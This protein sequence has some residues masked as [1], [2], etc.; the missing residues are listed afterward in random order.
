GAVR[1]D[2]GV[3]PD[4]RMVAS[5]LPAGLLGASMQSVADKPSTRRPLVP[6]TQSP[7]EIRV[8][9]DRRA[10]MDRAFTVLGWVLV[11]VSLGA[12]A[13]LLGDLFLQ[14]ISR[15]DA[16]FL[17]NFPSR[18]PESAGILS[19]WVGSALLMVVTASV[20]VPMGVAAGLYL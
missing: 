13:V 10:R 16:S 2:D 17:S 15:I 3:Q 7:E 14:G 4:W 1:N 6:L 18:K 11:T 12:L 19:A 8:V 5:T 20:A 9:A